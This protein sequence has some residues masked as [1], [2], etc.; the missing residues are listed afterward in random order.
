MSESRRQLLSIGVFCII[1]VVAI[2]LYAAAI[3][4][5]WANIFQTIL[6]LFGVWMLVLAA[7]RAQNPQKYEN[8]SFSTLEMGVILIALGAAWF[9]LSINWLYSLALLILVIGATAIAAALRRK[10]P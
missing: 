6:I 3:I 7:I 2:L 8:S 9:L 5:N 1:V 4:T 10:K